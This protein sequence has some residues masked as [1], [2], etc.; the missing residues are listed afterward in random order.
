MHL[1]S[2]LLRGCG[3]ECLAMSVFILSLLNDIQAR[4]ALGLTSMVITAHCAH[5]L[6][7]KVWKSTYGNFGSLLFY[8]WMIF[9]ASSAANLLASKEV[10]YFMGGVI[11]MVTALKLPSLFEYPQIAEEEL[12]TK[13][14]WWW[15]EAH[16][17]I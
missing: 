1:R 15:K 6:V 4:T 3:Y 10:G 14:S 8:L 5:A 16:M 17:G 13:N 12:L 7:G 11:G 2:V 9:H